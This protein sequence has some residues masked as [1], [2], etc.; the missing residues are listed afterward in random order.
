MS[1]SPAH[2]HIYMH[3]HIPAY[4]QR[5]RQ[6]HGNPD[7]FTQMWEYTQRHGMQFPCLTQRRCHGHRDGLSP[8]QRHK[9]MHTY[10]S[11]VY[12]AEDEREERL[13]G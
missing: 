5:H 13:V 1:L 7:T 11:S 4:V 8:A 2:A 6:A 10:F 12:H 9:H 3:T